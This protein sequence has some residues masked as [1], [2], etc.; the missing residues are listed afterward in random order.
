MA[1][2]VSEIYSPVIDQPFD[3]ESYTK[4][5]GEDTIQIHA[6]ALKEDDVVLIQ[7]DL[8]ATLQKNSKETQKKSSLK[9]A[10]RLSKFVQS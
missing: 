6:D 10:Q 4:E 2:T 9:K 3:E 7:D 1:I 5:Y 8:L